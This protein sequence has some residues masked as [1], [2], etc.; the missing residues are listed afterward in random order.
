MKKLLLISFLMAS[1]S[2][3]AYAMPAVRG[4]GTVASGSGAITL[5]LPAGTVTGDILVA[6]IEST[7]TVQ[8]PGWTACPNS[9]VATTGAASIRTTLNMYWT[10]Y[11]GSDPTLL[12]TATGDHQVG[13]I[14]GFYQCIASSD[15]W[16]VTANGTEIA[17]DTSGSIPGATTTIDDELIYAVCS[18]TADYAS[19]SGYSGW[20]NASLS[21]ITE[22]IDNTVTSGNGGGIGSATGGKATAGAYNATGVT[23][24]SGCKSYKAF[25]SGALK[26]DIKFYPEWTSSDTDFTDVIVWGDYDNDGFLDFAAGS[27]LWD[28]YTNQ[29]D[30]I[31]HN[32]G[33]GTFTLVWTSPVQRINFGM[34][35]GDYDNDG[36]LDLLCAYYYSP[37]TVWRNDGFGVFTDVW[38]NPD[39]G[40]NNY[41]PAWGD[42]DNDGKLDFAMAYLGFQT[43][44]FHNDGGGNFSLAWSA[45]FSS[46]ADITTTWVDYNN[47]GYTDLACGNADPDTY[48]RV[49]R[50]NK[51]GTF[52]EIWNSN[53]VTTLLIAGW[54]DYDKDG[55]MDF[56]AIN[57]L[58]KVCV[59][60]NNANDTFS[61]V[62]T[63]TESVSSIAGSVCWGDYDNDGNIDLAAD[64]IGILRN[65]GS[66]KFV[67]TW[68]NTTLCRIAWGDY[69]NDGRL[70]FACA[71]DNGSIITNPQVYKNFTATANTPPDH[72]SSITASYQYSVNQSTLSIKWPPAQYDVGMSS[73]SLYYNTVISSYPM[74]FSGGLVTSP[75]TFTVCWQYGTP[76]MGNYIRPAAEIWPGDSDVDHCFMLRSTNTILNDTTYYYS[77]QTI[78]AGLSRSDW[79][80]QQTVRTDV[81]PSA[82]NSLTSTPGSTA[83]SINLF[84]TAAGD[85]LTFG[86]ITGGS[87]RVRWSTYSVADW[88]SG[89][90]TDYQN[91][92]SID[93]S[94]NITALSSQTRTITGLKDATTYYFRVWTGDEVPNWSGISNG[95]TAQTVDFTLPPAPINTLSAMTTYYYGQVLLSWASPGNNG[96][97]G[98]L[99]GQYRVEYATWTGVAWSTNTSVGTGY[100]VTIST[101]NVPP[102]TNIYQKLNGLIPESTFYFR[103]WTANSQSGWSAISNGATCYVNGFWLDEEPM[104]MSVGTWQGSMAWGDYDNDGYVDLA[105]SGDIGTS[106]SPRFIIFKNVNG[107]FSTNDKIE[108]M[109]SSG[110]FDYFS[111]MCWADYDNDGDLDL[112][113]AGDDTVNGYRLIIFKNVNNTFSTSNIVEPIAANRGLCQASMDWGDYDNDG[114]PDLVVAGFDNITYIGRFIIFRNVKGVLSMAN[115]QQPLGSTQGLNYGSVK[116]G[117]YDN[118]GNLDLL[119]MGRDNSDKRRLIFFK[120][121]NDSFTLTNCQQPMGADYGEY[122]AAAAWGDYDND[123]DLDAVI[124]GRDDYWSVQRLFILKNVNG[125]FS[126]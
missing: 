52:T 77:V 55:N 97:A 86:N 19:T 20:S 15:P 114:W 67:N 5:V 17:V 22:R 28:P 47:D 41:S 51:N 66:N 107:S 92:Y 112:T 30:K 4:V 89:A 9:P 21:G 43:R 37:S 116:W 46:E 109:G 1:F 96:S 82:L 45:P 25:W 94:T 58:N 33:D 68:N 87:Y 80:P 117:D 119:A 122:Y 40:E 121:V 118:D 108:P 88:S 115:S 75:S 26:P 64:G 100:Y 59:Y 90:W 93:I 16:D 71:Y 13:R 38:E 44:V 98:N 85:D 32:N 11:T 10:R 78:D 36:D 14:V 120:N 60:R 125:T 56:A 79:A 126:T 61:S 124:A 105:I 91:R 54:G 74:N 123:G 7:G 24:A 27:G 65:M 69:D 103:V 8:L 76:L 39:G 34:A 95:T 84:W 62:W 83:G 31:Y 29:Y 72:P 49:F 102:G 53:G 113:V 35:W 57:D 48:S 23:Y 81:A 111:A 18:S 63:S 110:G 6:A 106:P 2:C 101:Q 12:T 99:T 104:G 42:Y 70:D 50:N 73:N 3:L